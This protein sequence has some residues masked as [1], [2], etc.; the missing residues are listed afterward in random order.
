MTRILFALLVGLIGLFASRIGATEFDTD[1]LGKLSEAYSAARRE[2]SSIWLNY[3]PCYVYLHMGGGEPSSRLSSFD[4]DDTITKSKSGRFLP[5]DATDWQYLTDD[6]RDKIQQTVADGQR[7]VLF[8]NQNG[9]G[10]R[11]VTLESVQKRLEATV[12]GLGVPCTIFVAVNKDKFRKPQSGMYELFVQ[13]FNGGKQIDL[14]KSFYCGDAIG[15]PAFSDSDI[16]FARAV[17]LPF[18]NPQEFLRGDKP[19]R[20]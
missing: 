12:K 16:R 7:L 9:V 18:L 11:I 13:A 1:A 17:G 20:N 15:H 10:A 2:Q 8:T 3:G 6:T 5:K 19:T 14:D 4:I